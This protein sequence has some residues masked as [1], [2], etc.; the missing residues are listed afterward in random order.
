MALKFART[1]TVSLMKNKEDAGRLLLARRVR[2]L[3]F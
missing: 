2:R 1:E 3:P